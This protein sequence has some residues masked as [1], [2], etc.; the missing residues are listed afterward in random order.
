MRW[1]SSL[2]VGSGVYRAISYGGDVK[3]I[4]VD[5]CA[6]PVS[7][8]RFCVANILKCV[9]WVGLLG[10]RMTPPQSLIG[11]CSDGHVCLWL[12]AEVEE[13]EDKLKSLEGICSPI[14]SKMYQGGARPC[15][16]SVSH[17]GL[18][19]LPRPLLVSCARQACAQHFSK[20]LQPVRAV[21]AG[22]VVRR[23]CVLHAQLL[24]RP[25]GLVTA[26]QA[27][28]AGDVAASV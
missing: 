17:A 5:V 15:L 28:R 9:A 23:A 1:H 2:W 19:R 7:S 11:V 16:A 13:M 8:T 10:T 18:A 12:Q 27:G 21:Q 24:H 4:L 6:V 14:I 26:V 25:C 20:A 3:S 22:E